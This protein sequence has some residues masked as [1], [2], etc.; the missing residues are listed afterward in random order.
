MEARE[1]QGELSST[2]IM[3]S[4]SFFMLIIFI[5]SSFSA[6]EVVSQ[7]DSYQHGFCCCEL[8]DIKRES[9]SAVC[10]SQY[11]LMILTAVLAGNY[12]I[13][14]STYEPGLVGDFQLTVCSNTQYTI[15]S[16][17]AEGAGMFRKVI[18]SEW[19]VGYNAMGCSTYRNYHRNPRYL[20]EIREL[21]T[22]R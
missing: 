12:T 11:D 19:I 17:P 6:R 1:L 21:T 22:V 3:D 15:D 4:F 8:R 7:T 18:N 14:A 5:T 20:L 13:I 9:T 2:F 10:G 16:I